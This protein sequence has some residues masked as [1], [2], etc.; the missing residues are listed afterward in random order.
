MK[1][2]YRKRAVIPQ[3]KIDEYLLSRTH[4]TGKHKAVLF[5]RIGFNE[6]NK[7]LFRDALLEIAHSN[8]INKI[9]DIVKEGKYFGKSYE[10]VGTLRGVT[11]TG[12]LEVKTVWKILEN[13]RIPSLVTVSFM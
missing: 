10:I 5:G 3:A 13:K 2:P 12:T 9:R 8:D 7:D 4:E 6:T 1:L 11:G